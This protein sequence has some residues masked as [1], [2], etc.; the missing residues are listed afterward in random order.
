MISKKQYSKPEVTMVPLDKS[1][2][3]MV[4]TPG[5]PNPP[6]RSGSKKGQETF[7]SP[8]GDKPFS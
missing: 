6:P 7:Q 4:V 5:P 8:F 3:L 2:C 1:I